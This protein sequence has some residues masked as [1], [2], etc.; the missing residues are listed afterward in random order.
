MK[1]TG[2]G[3]ECLGAPIKLMNL[4]SSASLVIH[5]H[6]SVTGWQTTNDNPP[7]LPPGFKYWCVQGSEVRGHVG[8]KIAY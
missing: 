3:L 1:V 2:C 4:F 6:I 5:Y 7:P 8:L